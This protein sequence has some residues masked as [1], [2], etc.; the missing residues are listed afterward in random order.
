MKLGS[1]KATP[2]DDL[3]GRVFSQADIFDDDESISD[4]FVRD[5][6]LDEEEKSAFWSELNKER[7]RRKMF[8]RARA[9][10]IERELDAKFGI[11]KGIAPWVQ[12]AAKVKLYRPLLN[13]QSTIIVLFLAWRGRMAPD[14]VFFLFCILFQLH[15]FVVVLFLAGFFWPKKYPKEVHLD[16]GLSGLYAGALLCRKCKVVVHDAPHHLPVRLGQLPK[17]ERLLPVKATWLP[18]GTPE[19]HFAYKLFASEPVTV[20]R[21]GLTSLDPSIIAQAR[22]VASDYFPYVVSQLPG[23]GECGHTYRAAMVPVS[24]ANLDP[25]DRELVSDADN[26]ADWCFDLCHQLDGY[27]YSPDLIAKLREFIRDNGGSVMEDGETTT[28][29]T[30]DSDVPPLEVRFWGSRDKLI[31]TDKCYALG[32]R[33]FGYLTNPHTLHVSTAESCNSAQ[34]LIQ[35]WKTAHL[36]AG[37]TKLDMLYKHRALSNY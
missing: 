36:K 12:L 32:N 20:V 22:I 3:S 16:G 23:R 21:P 29:Q 5:V 26:F 28:V 30:F 31:F 13:M 18:I 27:H 34:A 8:E 15:P 9:N 6:G 4:A 14:K 10:R 2:F 24:E 33:K 7:T 11:F 17:Y 25:V 19:D 1:L 37:F 35:G